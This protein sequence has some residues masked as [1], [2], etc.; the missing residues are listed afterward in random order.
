MTRKN[1]LA[2][3]LSLLAL[4][5]AAVTA[6]T[7]TVPSRARAA[8][9]IVLK[10][11]TVVPKNS[12]WIQVLQDMADDWKTI[13]NGQVQ[14][15]L[16]G[17]GIAGDDT[18]VVRKIKLGTLDGSLLSVTGLHTLDH[19]VSAMT[20]PMM[21]D[22]SEEFYGVLAM[23][24]PDLD[25][26]YEAQGLVVLHWADAGMVHFLTKEPVKTPDDLRKLK[27][28]TWQ[29]DAS[30]A[31]DLW[32]QAG[33]NAVPLP[34][35]EITTA[36]QTG[37]ISALPTSAEPAALLQWNQ[38]A[39]YMTNIN[40]AVLIGATVISKK[41]WDKIPA[42]LQPKLLASAAKYGQKLRDATHDADAGAIKAMTDRKLIMV[43]PDVDAWRKVVEPTW[44]NIRGSLVPAEMFDKVKAARDEWRAKHPATAAPG[45]KK[46]DAK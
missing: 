14:V 12:V 15:K 25:K 17:G 5:L 36:L 2:R 31:A 37:L 20:V 8:D 1:I 10:I 29:D 34:S 22:S 33:F 4:T 11:A 6:V 46:A 3:F 41:S 18:D 26:K 40:W 23:V 19:S 30:G 27:I 24:E 38:H 39:N 9:T 32:K 21:F 35:T 16:Y 43:E 7:V 45:V 42:D 13:S 44:K 28:F